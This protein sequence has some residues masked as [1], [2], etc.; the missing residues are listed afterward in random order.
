MIPQQKCPQCP[1]NTPCPVA[2]PPAPCPLEADVIAGATKTV[3]IL[4]FNDMYNI[5]GSDGVGGVARAATV[6]K[7]RPDSLLVFSGDCF[8]PSDLSSLFRG[9]QMVDTFNQMGLTVAVPGNH[10]FDGGIEHA[11]SLFNQTNF[12]WLLANLVEP[13]T[14]TPIAG[15]KR[16]HVVQHG[17]LKIGFFGVASDWR[18]LTAV[19]NKAE[20]IYI[21]TCG[22]ELAAELK[23][24]GV[25][26]IVALTH[27]TNADD[28]LLLS[29]VPDID[30]LLGGHDHGLFSSVHQVFP[31]LFIALGVTY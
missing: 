7:E 31:G 25:D 8:F 5:E 27:S 4:H 21:E 19:G 11:E 24:Q 26:L 9:Q 1:Q 17:G 23:A 28:L 16:T 15:L 13:G 14:K 2:S 20:Y 29:N 10:E 12:P 6:R 3:Q 30:V 18:F 22:A